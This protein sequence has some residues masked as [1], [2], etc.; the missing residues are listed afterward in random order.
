[1]LFVAPR[2]VSSACLSLAL[3]A[4]CYGLKRASDAGAPDAASDASDVSGALDA[5]DGCAGVCGPAPRALAPLSTVRLTGQHPTLQWALPTG[6][7]RARVELCYDRACARVER[8]VE[9]TG[10]QWRPDD[11]LPAGVYFW[12]LRALNPSAVVSQ[13]SPAWEF[14]VGAR[15]ASVDTS[16][17][18]ALDV[19]ADGL[20]DLAV[21]APTPMVDGSGSVS[22][23]HGAAGGVRATESMRLNAPGSVAGL[24]YSLASAGDTNGDGYA[25]L[26]V[27]YHRNG[28]DGTE[29][30]EGGLY[31]YL[32]GPTGLALTPAA[33]LGS[34]LGRNSNFG[35]IGTPN[36]LGTAGD[37]NGDGYADVIV[38]AWGPP[39]TTPG[40]AYVYLGGPTGITSDAAPAYELSAGPADSIFGFSVLSADFN[41]DGFSD[42]VCTARAPHGPGNAYVYFGTAMGLPSAPSVSLEGRASA[43]GYGEFFGWSTATAD[44]NGDGYPDLAVGATYANGEGRMVHTGRV[45][46]YHGGPA[47]LGL[48]AATAA[49]ELTNPAFSSRY[50]ASLCAGD[51][52]ADGYDDLLIGTQDDQQVIRIYPGG[53]MG[54][55]DVVLGEL[56]AP[57]ADPQF[58]L[59][60]G[61]CGDADGDGVP[62]VLV[63]SQSVNR[64]Y[65]YTG[66]RDAT[67]SVFAPA[68]TLTGTPGSAFGNSV[69]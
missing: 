53:A 9:V 39:V 68:L 49:I 55:S 19:N 29:H 58:G 38:G 34:R 14:F 37:V 61:Y 63:G 25:D 22:V 20:V 35:G 21:G 32:G 66:W 65:V 31:V 36:G 41:G 56:H 47:G 52:N 13:P 48:D 15:A 67:P 50:G 54:V 26:L 42:V 33:H 62:E 44:V 27:G 5:S 2:S 45:N 30:G 59:E 4:G 7:S 51:M 24:G 40:R 23:F 60:A 1:M 3:L 43:P 17:G 69:F 46:V 6:V 10:E 57:F 11:P 28:P 8:S 12:R 16:Y 64:A 18:S